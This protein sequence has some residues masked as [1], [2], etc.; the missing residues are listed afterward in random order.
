MLGM[1]IEYANKN[2][3]WLEAMVQVK[4]AFRQ[5]FSAD[6]PIFDNV[7]IITDGTRFAH[8]SS[9]R[10]MAEVV[11]GKIPEKTKRDADEYLYNLGLVSAENLS[12]DMKIRT[13][14]KPTE[15]QKK[16]IEGLASDWG[17]DL[18]N[19][20]IVDSNGDIRKSPDA[21]KF[22]KQIG[23]GRAWYAPYYHERN[24]PKIPLRGRQNL[25]RMMNSQQD[26]QNKD[27]PMDKTSQREWR[28]FNSRRAH[29]KRSGDVEGHYTEEQ[30]SKIRGLRWGN[31]R[32]PRRVSRERFNKMPAFR[33][34]YLR[35]LEL[36][37]LAKSQDVKK[38]KILSA[39]IFGLVAG[40]GGFMAG[41][42]VRKKLMSYGLSADATQEAI[43]RAQNT[44]YMLHNKRLRLV[45]K[46]DN[47]TYIIDNPTVDVAQIL[48]LG[49]QVIDEN[50]REGV[51]RSV[52]A[53]VSKMFVDDREVLV[54]NKNL[55]KSDEVLYTEKYGL[56]T[57][58]RLDVVERA[59]IVKACNLPEMHKMS[60]WNAF[61]EMV[62][63]YI[64]LKFG[65]DEVKKAMKVKM[66]RP[67]K[68][69]YKEEAT[70]ETSGYNNVNYGGRKDLE[71]TYGMKRV[72]GKMSCANCNKMF[73]EVVEKCDKCGNIMKRHE[74]LDT[75]KI[76]EEANEQITDMKKM[77][78]PYLTK[79]IDEAK[80]QK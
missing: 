78:S 44:A 15:K 1:Y 38:G 20:V 14:R 53:S 41:Q 11:V 12:G 71:N 22:W 73:D 80:A 43:S 26:Y 7:W 10:E 59:K 61:G 13:W 64:R 3:D 45:A 70:S 63:D 32:I 30:A 50:G 16:S 47:I 25:S 40:G 21:S 6:E 27:P 66:A 17:V 67:K 68:E 49:D 69:K 18:T 5:S 2:G 35:G 24:W 46:G 75:T 56:T 52:G 31:R 54:F 42:L 9:L 33:T 51:M 55:M 58:D 65:D 62:Q 39:V 57:W 36:M 76:A 19:V 72:T 48:R 28:G 29:G 8:G 74:K 79:M 34:E 23:Y 37:G 4:R 60:T 77:R